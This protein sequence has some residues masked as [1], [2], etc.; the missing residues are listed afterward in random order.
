MIDNINI[1]KL[2]RDYDA[3]PY[4]RVEGCKLKSTKLTS[5]GCITKIKNLVTRE[6]QYKI[7]S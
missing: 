4:I 7:E 3:E 5:L 2:F 6:V 1:E